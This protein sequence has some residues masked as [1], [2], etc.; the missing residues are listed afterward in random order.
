MINEMVEDEKLSSKINSD[1]SQ[2]SS[3]ILYVKHISKKCIY[4]YS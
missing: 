2:K 1:F 4:F 3:A